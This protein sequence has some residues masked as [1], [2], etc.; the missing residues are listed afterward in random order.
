MDSKDKWIQ[1][2]ESSIDGIQ[3]A[4]VTPYLYNKILMKLRNVSVNEVKPKLVWASLTTFI[5]LIL[6]N[7]L[8]FR[9][10]LNAGE[11]DTDLKQLSGALHLLNENPINY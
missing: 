6:L 5:V 7:L 9:L 3:Q 1:E 4:E 10:G 8:V 2:V 11:P